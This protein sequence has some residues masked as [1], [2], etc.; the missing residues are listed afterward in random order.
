MTKNN[1]C[2]AQNYQNWK[3]IK[4]VALSA[5]HLLNWFYSFSLNRLSLICFCNLKKKKL[6]WKIRVNP[7]C[8]PI[9]PFKNNPFWH[10][11]RLTRKPDWPDPPILPHLRKI[12]KLKISDLLAKI[13]EM[14]LISDDKSRRDF[15][16]PLNFDMVKHCKL[17]GSYF[18]CN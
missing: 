9:N 16:F 5:I 13:K 1:F 6:V 14:R 10:V 18:L 3:D 4:Q 11:I 2:H 8:N 7:T 17:L 12:R 15:A